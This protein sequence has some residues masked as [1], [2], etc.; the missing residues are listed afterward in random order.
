VGHNEIRIWPSCKRLLYRFEGC[1]HRICGHCKH[2]FGWICG[3]KWHP[4]H[5]SCHGPWNVNDQEMQGRD[6]VDRDVLTPYYERFLK[7]RFANANWDDQRAIV[8]KALAAEQ[9]ERAAEV[10]QFMM[11]QEAAA[12][13]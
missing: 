8:A 12:D 7:V 3:V 2:Q 11:M 5:D 13:P 6:E 1:V 9:P 10:K 4:A